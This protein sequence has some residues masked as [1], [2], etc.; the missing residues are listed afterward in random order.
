MSTN[1][2]KPVKVAI[3]GASGTYGTHYGAT[4]RIDALL[5]TPAEVSRKRD[6][7]QLQNRCT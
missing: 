7:R 3:I 6:V 2:A 4:Y 1:V 5:R